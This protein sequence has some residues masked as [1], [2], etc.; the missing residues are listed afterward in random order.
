MAAATTVVQ[1]PSLW[2]M[3]V[4][5]DFLGLEDHVG[6]FQNLPLLVPGAVGIELDAQDGGEHLGGQVFGVIGRGLGGL[7]VSMVLGEIAECVPIAGIATPTLAATSRF[8]S[9]VAHSL[10]TTWTIWP[11]SSCFSPC[12]IEISLHRGGKML[13]TRTRL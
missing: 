10:M 7:P 8:G 11:G 13:E 9:A 4:W 12:S 2:P 1:S 3:A 5:V 6:D